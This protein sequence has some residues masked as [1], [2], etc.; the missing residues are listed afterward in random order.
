MKKC[1]AWRLVIL[2][3]LPV[4][5]STHAHSSDI[6]ESVLI[7][8]SA[9]EIVSGKEN[10]ADVS[11]ELRTRS[12]LG[13]GWSTKVLPTLGVTLST[14]NQTDT[15]Y[16]GATALYHLTP[17]VFIEGFFGLAVH[18]ADTPRNADG[19]DL[20]CRT[21]FR[22]AVGVGYQHEQH[23]IALHLSH[24]S[25]GDLLCDADANDGMT[26]LAVRYGYTF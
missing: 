21:L 17:N 22:E 18:D 6:L 26:S 10:G 25:H 19:L 24:A 11:L 1:A 20:G 7:G 13:K 3:L 15:A 12:L 23:S 9:H 4:C 5:T 14:S 8:I 2:F 16:V